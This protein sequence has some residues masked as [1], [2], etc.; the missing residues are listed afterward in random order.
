MPS[1]HATAVREVLEEFRSLH[2]LFD[3]LDGCLIFVAHKQASEVAAKRFDAID[4]PS[5]R[6]QRHLFFEPVC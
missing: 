5:L 3:D 4:V 1:C 2:R 6:D